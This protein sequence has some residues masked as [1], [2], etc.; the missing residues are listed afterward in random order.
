MTMYDWISMGFGLGGII[1]GAVY[2]KRMLEI[3][4]QV[5]KLEKEKFNG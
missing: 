2:R 3:R 5:K 4:E 1:A